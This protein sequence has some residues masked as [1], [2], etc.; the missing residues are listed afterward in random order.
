MMELPGLTMTSTLIVAADG[1]LYAGGGS[2]GSRS[3]LAVWDGTAW[4]SAADFEGGGGGGVIALAVMDSG[5]LLVGGAFPGLSGVLS[6]NIALYQPAVM[7]AS[8]PTASLAQSLVVAPNPTRGA[9][10]L[11]ATVPAGAAEVSVY[12]A[13][14]RHVAVAF[15]GE[16]SGTLSVPLDLSG[17]APGVYVV[18]LSAGDAVETARFVVAR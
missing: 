17:L 14:G 12:D 13:L 2:F 11:T 9:A 8:A 15:E 16:T 5:D 3:V 6:S 10:R 18:R 4:E 1:R 7:D